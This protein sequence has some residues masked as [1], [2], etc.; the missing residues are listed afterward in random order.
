MGIAFAIAAAITRMTFHANL[1]PFPKVPP[2]ETNRPQGRADAQVISDDIGWLITLSDLTLLL[3]CFLVLFYVKNQERN[4]RAQGAKPAAQAANASGESEKPLPASAHASDWSAL[5]EEIERFIAGA[6]I[7]D[8]VFIA[9]APDE[10]LLSFKDT[11]PFASGKADLRPEA[12][13]V[14]EKVAAVA[15]SRPAM[16][17]EINGH[18]DDRPIFTAEFPSNWE[19]SSTRASRVARYLIEKGVHPTRIAVHGFAN[20]RPRV[21]NGNRTGRGANRRVEL[22]LMRTSEAGITQDSYTPSPSD[23][24]FQQFHQ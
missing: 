20:H 23:H 15:V 6:G 10:I 9:A 17:L 3:L 16:H 12:L 24:E 11:V 13:P 21:P 1:P 4:A 2:R 8:D 18:T 5:R 19:L 22:R 14:L 7:S